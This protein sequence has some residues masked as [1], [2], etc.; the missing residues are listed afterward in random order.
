M[1]HNLHHDKVFSRYFL[2]WCSLT[3]FLTDVGHHDYTE[4]GW[5]KAWSKHSCITFDENVTVQHCQ[6]DLE[7]T[8]H[9]VF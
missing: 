3:E 8:C 6:L 1:A 4:P 5:W 7:P 9:R 2:F